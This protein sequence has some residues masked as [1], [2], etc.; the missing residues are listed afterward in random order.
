MV[1]LTH[2]ADCSLKAINFVANPTVHAVELESSQD[3]DEVRYAI[4]IYAIPVDFN[5][6]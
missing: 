4:E 6:L 3:G 1:L 5:Y 2:F